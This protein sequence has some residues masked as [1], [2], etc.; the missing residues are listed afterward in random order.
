MLISNAGAPGGEGPCTGIARRAVAAIAL[1][2]AAS[3]GGC[4]WAFMTRPPA[5][6][7]VGSAGYCTSN[8]AAPVLDTICA[9]YFALNAVALARAP[10]CSTWQSASNCV[11]S[12]TKSSGIGLSLLIGG[13]CTASAVS[14]YSSSAQCRAM[15]AGWDTTRSWG[16]PAGRGSLPEPA[17]PPER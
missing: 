1:V 13:L 2:L 11:D 4:S 8:R 9:S 16:G 6:G 12:G 7:A 3:T 5:A 15:Q 14:G 10:T 17:D